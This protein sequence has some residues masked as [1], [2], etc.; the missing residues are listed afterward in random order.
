MCD[1]PLLFACRK[2]K[3]GQPDNWGHGHEIGEDCAGLIHD[4]LWND[5]YC[6]DLISFICEKYMDTCTSIS[7]L[8]H[9]CFC[10]LLA[11]ATVYLNVTLSLPAAT[12]AGMQRRLDSK[13]KRVL[14][15]AARLHPCGTGPL[16]RHMESPYGESKG[17]NLYWAQGCSSKRLNS[18]FRGAFLL[19]SEA[20]KCN[21]A[22]QPKKEENLFFIFIF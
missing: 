19:Q 20:S 17:T 16:T 7:T 14:Q 5:F 22:E 4:G 10:L 18:A 2:W 3:P 8:L 21:T 9:I 6:E 15:W 1:R 11:H 13:W 12:T